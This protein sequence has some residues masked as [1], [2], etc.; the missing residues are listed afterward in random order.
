VTDPEDDS[1]P[2]LLN[3]AT[4]TEISAYG[5]REQLALSSPIS[6]SIYSTSVIEGINYY[7]VK[8]G[9][10]LNTIANTFSTTKEKLAISNS[11]VTSFDNIYVGQLICVDGFN[12][13]NSFN[14][15]DKTF[16]NNS[17]FLD[18]IAKSA[19]PI[20][21]QKGLYASVMIAQAIHES[22]WAKSALATVGNNLFGVKGSYQGRS[23]V[24]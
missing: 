14:K 13:Y 12:N 16:S 6:L 9:D 24:M 5:N 20:A 8:A 15:E 7:Y 22:A 1:I 18:Y 11:Q 3:N 4:I 19:V 2:S 10:N 21:E 23:I 17:E